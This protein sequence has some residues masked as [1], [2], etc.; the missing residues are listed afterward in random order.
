MGWE[1]RL[2][3]LEQ[4]TGV[5]IHEATDLRMRPHGYHAG[6][7]HPGSFYPAWVNDIH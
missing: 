7:M 6:C 1:Q 4:Y 5:S 2:S 3:K